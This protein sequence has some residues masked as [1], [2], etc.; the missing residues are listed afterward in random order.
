MSNNS[1]ASDKSDGAEARHYMTEET[2]TIAVVDDDPAQR[3]LLEN[4]LARAGYA[5]IL[6]EDGRQALNAVQDCDLMLL[7]VRMPGMSGM[8]VLKQVRALRP[9]LP[10]IL[11]T[12]YIDVRDAV[13]AI[14]QGAADYLEKP[15]D[16]DELI[17][18]I[19]DAL[20][21]S[22]NRRDELPLALPEDIVAES[23]AMRQVFRQAAQVAPSDA[24]VL[25][26]GE[27]GTGKEVVARFI[28]QASARADKA[29]VAV[30]CASLPESLVESEL[31]GHEKGAFTGATDAR[32]GHF[33][34]AD[35]GTLFLDEVG[36][37]PLSLQPKLLRVI[38]TGTYRRVGGDEEQRVDVR[39]IAATNR[40]LEEEVRAGRFREDLFFRINVFPLFIPPLRERTDDVLP[41]AERFLQ[42]SR[43]RL[44]PAAQRLLLDYEWPGNV[45]ELR[46]A[47]ERAAIVAAGGLVLPA[48]LPTSVQRAKPR[49][50]Q[51]GV[52]VGDMQEIQRRAILEAL[53]KT[54]GNKTR[55]AEMLGI[56]RRNLIYKLRAYGM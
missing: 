53:E 21:I 15:I 32:D 12:A 18:V 41:L 16:L 56:S 55:A 46:N 1:D 29:L 45:R 23:D 31:F 5:C 20:G 10:V 38:E 4:A 11:L 54:G 37:L 27:S 49:E 7:D 52:L 25:I 50:K 19:E 35:G 48:D 36:E 42:S 17:A 39:M 14:K 9:A 44:A 34:S 47:M 3:A 13:A 43:K 51:R 24:T 22:A 8:E 6:C 40:N 26:L 33:E 28:H 30:D 2:L